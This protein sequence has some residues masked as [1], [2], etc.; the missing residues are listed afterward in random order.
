MKMACQWRVGEVVSMD[1]ETPWVITRSI[2]SDGLK[3][4]LALDYVVSDI[5]AFDKLTGTFN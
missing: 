2:M 4:I 3:A 1:Q 5:L